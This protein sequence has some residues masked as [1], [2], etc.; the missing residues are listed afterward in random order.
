MANCH[1]HK[2][3]LAFHRLRPCEGICIAQTQR[4]VEFID[5]ARQWLPEGEQCLKITLKVR[6]FQ[7]LLGSALET[8]W[9]TGQSNPA[10]RR[11]AESEQTSLPNPP[12]V[13][14]RIFMCPIDHLPA[15]SLPF[16]RTSH[17]AAGQPCVKEPCGSGSSFQ[18]AGLI[19]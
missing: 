14:G 3:Q 1:M 11:C 2:M 9:Q 6:I 19:F 5:R 15:Y 16:Q 18:A 10:L 12:M 13:R 4:P 17:G 8:E 7:N